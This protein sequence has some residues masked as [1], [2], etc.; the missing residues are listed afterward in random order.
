V[1][2]FVVE[3]EICGAEFEKMEEEGPVPEELLEDEDIGDE[4]DH[5]GL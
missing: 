5:R 1:E 2:S 3:C 4:V